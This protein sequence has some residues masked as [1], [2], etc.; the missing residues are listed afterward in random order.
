M[1]TLQAV[2]ESLA[3][4][5]QEPLMSGTDKGGTQTAYEI[6]KLEQNANTVLGLF[7]KMISSFV[8]QYGKLK[9]S[10][11][12]QYL[13]ITEVNMIEGKEHSELI[14]KTFLMPERTNEGKT[15]TRKIIFDSEMAKQETEIPGV[16]QMKASYEL[17]KE[18]KKSGNE[19]Y[20]VNPKLFRE[21][22]Y[23]LSV[24]PD[25]LQPTSEELERAYLLEEYDRAISNPL[26]DQKQ[27]TSDF[28]LAAY[29]KSKGNVDKY[30]IKEQPVQIPGQQAQPVGGN[31][32]TQGQES[33]LTANLNKTI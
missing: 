14:Y 4:S 21:L 2:E 23:K 32:Q 33:E 11:I 9:L 6:S 15:R 1:N 31:L 20:K 5:S 17:L 16:E 22:K 19:L 27:I 25:V 18:E 24:T 8:K 28:L 3:A 10:D 30:F 29:P 12:L 7:I 26:L 13:T